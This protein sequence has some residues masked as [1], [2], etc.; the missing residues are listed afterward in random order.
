M[1]A[2]SADRRS[3]VPAR[4][5]RRCGRRAAVRRRL[6]RAPAAR[7]DAR[8][9]PLPGRR[10]PGATSTTTSATRHN[11][12]M[13]DVLEAILTHAGRRRRRHAGARFTRYTKL[14][15]INTGPYNNLTAR[16]FV[17]RCDPRAPARRPCRAAASDG[18][19]SPAAGPAKRSTSCSRGCAPMFF[20]P[21]VRSD[22][23]E[24]DAGRGPR[25]P[26][27]RAPTT[28]TTASRWPTSRA[29]ASGTRSTRAS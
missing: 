20:D 19:P 22:G 3:P 28:C 2:V 21:D 29:S 26:R 23:H 16:K 5:G 11:L 25:H 17:L 10:S 12:E 7:E 15:W 18:A 6:R 1:H 27:R 9:A 24:Q 13:R 4:T 14:F 8:L